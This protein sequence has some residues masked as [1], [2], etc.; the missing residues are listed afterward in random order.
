MEKFDVIVVGAGNGGLVA[1]ASGSVSVFGSV[2]AGEI[3]AATA[4]GLLGFQS[5]SGLTVTCS[6]SWFVT[7]GADFE[8]Y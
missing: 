2:Y 6:Y 1:A 7:S 8:T 5:Q 4:F 3:T